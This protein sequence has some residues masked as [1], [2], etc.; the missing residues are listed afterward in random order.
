MFVFTGQGSQRPGMCRGLPA[1]EPVFAAAIDELRPL[2]EAESGFS[3]CEVVEYSERLVGLRGIQPAPFG[4]RVALAAVR[5]SPGT[6]SP[7]QGSKTPLLRDVRTSP[8]RGRRSA[9]SLDGPSWD[10]AAIS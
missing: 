7:R 5:R 6:H 3:L 2:I 1:G 9:A 10:A 4:V 8:A